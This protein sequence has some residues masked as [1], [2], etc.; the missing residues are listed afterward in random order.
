MI[1]IDTIAMCDVIAIVLAIR[2]LSAH[3]CSPMTPRLAA[4]QLALEYVHKSV[5]GVKPLSCTIQQ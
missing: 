3:V 5:N 4:L 1:R 2:S